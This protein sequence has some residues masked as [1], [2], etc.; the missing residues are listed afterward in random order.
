MTKNKALICRIELLK[1]EVI[2]KITILNRWP[3]DVATI[4]FN[5]ST[6]ANLTDDIT[7]GMY[8]KS[9]DEILNIWLLEQQMDN[10]LLEKVIPRGDEN[11]DQLTKLIN[12]MKTQAIIKNISIEEIYNSTKINKKKTKKK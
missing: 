9:P 4:K 8:E 12:D 3:Y 2:S 6:T 10:F 11:R 1:L 7:T 5:A